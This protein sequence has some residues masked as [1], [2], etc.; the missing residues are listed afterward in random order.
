[1]NPPNSTKPSVFKSTMQYTLSLPQRGLTAWLSRLRVGRKIAAGYIIVL[2]VA[3]AGSTLGFIWG[4]IHQQQAWQA[5]DHAH[6]EIE[7]YR[8][9][10]TVVLQTRTHQQQLIA[11]ADDFP[12]FAT[13]YEQILDYQATLTATW[14]ELEAFDVQS[15]KRHVNHEVHVHH[16][17][18]FLNTYQGV[19]PAYFEQLATL[20]AGFGPTPSPEEVA[21]MRVAL[22][23]FTNSPL[24]LHFDAISD[25]L[26][27]LVNHA[28]VEKAAIEARLEDLHQLRLYWLVGSVGLSI[29]IAVIWTIFASQAIAQ[30]LEEVTKVAKAVT[31]DGDFER[32]AVVKTADEVGTVA[33]AL[34]QLIDYVKHL[35]AEQK[36]ATAQQLLASEKMS[37]LGRMVAGVAHEINNPV[38]FIHGNLVHAHNYIDDLFQLLEAYERVLAHIPA[39]LQAELEETAEELD[40]EFLKTDLP[41]LLQ[42]MQVG[43]DRTRQIVLSLR[44]FSRLDDVNPHNV[45]IHAC[46]DSTLLILNNR[47]KKGVDVVKNYG[48][49]PGVEGYSG[50]LYQVFMNILSNALDAL[51]GQTERRPQI[52][53]TTER[54]GGEQVA[55][56]IQDNGHGITPE[57]LENIFKTFFTTKPEGVG[58]G[59]GLAISYQIVV[60]KHQGSLTCTSKVGKQTTFTVLLPIHLSHLVNASPEAPAV[61]A[62]PLGA[63]VS[64]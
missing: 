25:Q 43:A 62:T 52:T 6:T 17:P 21:M 30:P 31:E 50:S 10:Q 54:R 28:R 39:D 24:T 14:I 35:L 2:T 32:Q 57:N 60:E 4:E 49:I 64:H 7:L 47:I 13:E 40:Q 27:E 22:M 20:V 12:A 8:Q 46:L 41:K 11:L 16:L 5:Q 9:L 45:D 34:N 51:E 59:L 38:N 3:I 15:V 58:T 42:S 26:V 48:N 53:L 18:H 23:E 44:N 61:A 37:S 33:I 63:L 19:P 56:A 36:A 1:M 55:I 29:L